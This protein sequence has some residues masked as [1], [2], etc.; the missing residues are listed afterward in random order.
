MYTTHQFNQ[1]DR[2]KRAKSFLVH[3]PS[4][5]IAV[6]KYLNAKL[7]SFLTRNKN[8]I[9]E[10]YDESSYL[11]S[12]WK[13]YPP[14]D[15]GR[16]P[17]HDQFPWIEVGEQVFGSKLSRFLDKNF[18]VKDPGIPSGSD[19][20]YL[21][22]SPDIRSILG[23]T[24][25]IWLFVDIKSVGPRDNFDHAVMSTYQISGS[26]DWSVMDQG[27]KN[28]PINAIGSRNNHLF[29]CSLPPIYVLSDETIA[30][31]VTF[32]IKP[33]YS[34]MHKG[35]VN[36]GQPLNKIKVASI[37]NGLLLTKEPNYIEQHPKLFF[38]GKD[39]KSKD[40]RKIRARVSFD[41]LKKID[42]WRV[43][44]ICIQDG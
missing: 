15:R 36:I 11:Y 17:K 28:E 37:P 33:V 22:S 3:S 14:E 4:S 26:G 44:E 10:D 16:A 32:A 20:R 43:R 7:W 23:F 29:Y 18:T 21:I 30:P 38:P 8:T 31:L 39:D 9:H 19:Y 6:E 34:M 13:N 24:D 27:V 12:F 35:N 41:I 5:L 1:W 25:S 40:L 2:Y 42:S